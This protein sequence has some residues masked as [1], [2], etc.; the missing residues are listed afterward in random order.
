[1]I[2]TH[3]AYE[4]VVVMEYSQ[5]TIIVLIIKNVSP[6]PD[7]WPNC[8]CYTSNLNEKMMMLMLMMMMDRLQI[9]S[10]LRI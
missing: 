3:N 7:I 6:L 4:L 5:V 2:E 8:I 10:N 1:M 9:Q